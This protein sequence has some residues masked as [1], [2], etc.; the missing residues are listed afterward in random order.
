MVKKVVGNIKL[1]I[2]A[3]KATPA[4]PVGPALGQHG[5]NIMEFCK[6]FNARTQKQEGLIIPAV[7]TV[8]SDRTYTFI[9]KTPPAAILLKRAAN[10]AKGSAEPNKTK[11]AKVTMKQIEE[12]AKTKMPDLNCTDLKAAMA[13]VMGTARSMGIEVQS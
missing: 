13:T 6:A 8:F 4:P 10:L 7:I 2:P 1:Q 11:V 9:T 5:L 3:G 12:I